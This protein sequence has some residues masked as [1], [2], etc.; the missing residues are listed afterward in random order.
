MKT[1]TKSSGIP[2][3]LGDSNRYSDGEKEISLIHPCRATQDSYEIYCISGDMFE[4]V[5]RYSTLQ[6]AESAIQ[7]YLAE[8]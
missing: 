7:K 6:E 1:E 4:D 8:K 5:V 2:G 3:L